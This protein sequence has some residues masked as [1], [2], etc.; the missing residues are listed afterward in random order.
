MPNANPPL[1]AQV[2]LRDGAD[3]AQAAA[4]FRRAGFDVG[5][6]L[7]GNFSISG[8][9]AHFQRFFAQTSAAAGGS[10]PLSQLPDDMR[11]L[12]RD[13]VISRVDFGPTSW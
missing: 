13:I 5:T 7:A 3:A 8:P 10:F 1:T 9:A 6:H 2:V 11:P 4:A 12:V